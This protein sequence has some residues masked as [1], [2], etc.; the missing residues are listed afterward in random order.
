VTSPK[1]IVESVM[2]GGASA[3]KAASLFANKEVRIEPIIAEATEEICSGCAICI[4][5]CPYGAITRKE[6]G[7]KMVAKVDK[8]LCK[9]CGT[10]VAACPSGAMQQ[11]GFKDI[12]VMAQ[13]AALTERRG[14]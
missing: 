5:M 10:C 1:N 4:A 9:A 14:G 7:E 11:S 13:V 12:Q 8:A 6:K 2:A 3:A